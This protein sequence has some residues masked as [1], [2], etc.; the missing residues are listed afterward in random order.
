MVL[1]GDEELAV[2]SVK[3]K[4]MAAKVEDTVPLD[5]LV[6]ELQTRLARQ[7]TSGPA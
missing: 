1:F 4:D 6:S 5:T 7:P 2:G 3:I